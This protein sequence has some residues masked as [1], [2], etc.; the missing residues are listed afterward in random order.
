ME[1]DIKN[2]DGGNIED[3]KINDGN[4]KF[5]VKMMPI[6]FFLFK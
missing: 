6:L 2:G 3:Y 5:I 1:D 4:I